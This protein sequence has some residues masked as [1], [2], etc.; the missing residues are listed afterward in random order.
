M[1]LLSLFAPR[2]MGWNTHGYKPQTECAGQ[3]GRLDG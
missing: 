3:D 2:N 1:P